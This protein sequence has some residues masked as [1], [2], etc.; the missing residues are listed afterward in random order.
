[1]KKKRVLLFVLAAGVCLPLLRFPFPPKSSPRE[2]LYEWLERAE[3]AVEQLAGGWE[4]RSMTEV[5]P[6]TYKC[7]SG[8]PIVYYICKTTYYQA[9]PEEAGLD[10]AAL[11]CV[12]DP[13][14]ADESRVCQVNGAEAM[15]YT[16]G[17]RAYLCWTAGPG[18]TFVL[19]CN[20][21]EVAEEDIFRMAESVPL[22]QGE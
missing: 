6:L 3:R 7:K 15:L 16:V 12:V 10:P 22:G 18:Y 21:G 14:T 9:V 20:P 19:E 2:E 17:E 11:A 1:M 8:D 13:E 4:K 5:V